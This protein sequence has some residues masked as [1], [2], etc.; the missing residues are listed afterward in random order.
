MKCDGF[1][2]VSKSGPQKEIYLRVAPNT[3]LRMQAVRGRD[4]APEMCVRKELHRMGY[5]FRVH[6]KSL[7]GT[8]DI[9]LPK[10][11][12]II[13][14]HGCFWHGHEGCR[15]SKV[16]QNNAEAW[17]EKIT[18]NKKR[19]QRDLMGLRNLGWRVLVIWECETR[20][21]DVTRIQLQKFFAR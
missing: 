14:V 17:H 16:P 4:T 6:Q 15:R 21:L 19:D 1:K 5:R 9:V 8:P 3:R 20:S 13:L 2:I 12:K 11:R 18:L 10:H 7:P